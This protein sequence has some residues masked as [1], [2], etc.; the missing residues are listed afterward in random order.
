MPVLDDGLVPLIMRYMLVI[1]EWRATFFIVGVLLSVF[2]F[3]QFAGAILR[4]TTAYGQG[5]SRGVSYRYGD[6]GFKRGRYL[7][8]DNNEVQ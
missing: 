2:A 1:W 8:D 5:Y 6:T 7:D 3:E 4:V